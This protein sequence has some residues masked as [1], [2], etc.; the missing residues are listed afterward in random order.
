MYAALPAF[1]RVAATLKPSND[2]DIRIEVWLPSSGWNGKFEGTGNGGWS[3]QISALN[4]VDYYTRA[5][6]AVGSATSA[7][8][9]RLFMIP[10]MRHCGGGP[11]TTDFNALD[12]R[13]HWVERKHAPDRIVAS[14]RTDNKIDRT[15]PLCPYP[16]VATYKGSGSTDDAANFVCA[17]PK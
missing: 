5:S 16:Q 14:H 3:G 10:G 1:C 17:A 7:Q 15:R 13:S 9:M 12:E 6:A 2:S 11:G 4:T 8:S